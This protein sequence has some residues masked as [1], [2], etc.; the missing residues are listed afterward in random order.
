MWLN[1]AGLYQFAKIFSM[2]LQ[3]NFLKFIKIKLAIAN[4]KASLKMPTKKITKN[5]LK[6]SKKSKK[7]TKIFNFCVNF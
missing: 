6:A 3:N 1:V 2:Q 7:T 5:C 4:A